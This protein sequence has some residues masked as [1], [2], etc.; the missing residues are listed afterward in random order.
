VPGVAEASDLAGLRV[1]LLADL[2]ARTAEL[3]KLQVLTVLATDDQPPRE[4]EAL[5]RAVEALAIHPPATRASSDGAQAALGGPIDVYLASQGV[6][7]D[8]RPNGLVALVGAARLYRTSQA[9]G[10][11]LAGNEDEPLAVRLA[12]LSFPYHQPADLTEDVLAR[13]SATVGHWRLQVAEWAESPSRPMPKQITETLRG[14]FDD[15]DTVS[16]LALLKG[17]ASDADLPPGAKFETFLYA[18]RILALDLPRD[19]GRA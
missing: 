14:A 7:A 4:R 5:E 13:A 15:L 3:R 8:D 19:I 18:D 17:L 1:L 6:R 9:A 11:L 16:A 12:L 10:E 2:L